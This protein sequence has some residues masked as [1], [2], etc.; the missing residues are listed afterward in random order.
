MGK[1]LNWQEVIS[2]FSLHE[3]TKNLGSGP[4]VCYLFVN[5]QL[6]HHHSTA[7][8]LFFTYS[9][10]KN[11]FYN[12]HSSMSIK[13]NYSP[14]DLHVFDKN[15]QQDFL[16]FWNF[17][18][19]HQDGDMYS[20]QFLNNI[21]YVETYGVQVCF[22]RVHLPLLY[23]MVPCTPNYSF[24]QCPSP[25]YPLCLFR[26]M[27]LF[28]LL[29]CFL[30]NESFSPPAVPT[31]LRLCVVAGQEAAIPPDTDSL[32]VWEAITSR[33][34]SPRKEIILNIGQR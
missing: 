17:P 2:G 4:W 21:K 34:K 19:S 11:I 7:Q 26:L 20:I 16:L 3:T 1:I 23:T 10:K 31:C 9:L 25:T 32:D 14:T 24:W 33:R 12:I 30:C 5:K 8:K 27:V 15:L 6:Q 22:H 18:Y 13:K 28:L 29:V